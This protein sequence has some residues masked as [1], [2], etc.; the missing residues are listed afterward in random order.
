VQV[1]VGQAGEQTPGEQ[2][3]IEGAINLR[4]PSITINEA[5]DFFKPGGF[6][7]RAQDTDSPGLN[8]EQA[9]FVGSVQNIFQTAPAVAN[10]S[11][12]FDGWHITIL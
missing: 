3:F 8:V 6:D 9:K 4:W 12:V 2:F 11:A 7:Q 5:A 1:R 10:R